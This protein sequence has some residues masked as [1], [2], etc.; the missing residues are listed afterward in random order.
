MKQLTTDVMIK[1]IYKYMKINYITVSISPNV[2]STFDSQW[3]VNLANETVNLLKLKKTVEFSILITSNRK[4]K[5]LNKKYRNIDEPT[6]VLSFYMPQNSN[7]KNVDFITP[8]DSLIHLGEIIISY[9]QTVKQAMEESVNVSMEL[10]VLTVHGILHLLGYDHELPE[11]EKKMREKE[12]EVKAKL[13]R[14]IP[15]LF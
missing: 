12:E 13:M 5:Q 14:F 15:L 8:P 9:E 2:S 6:D 4:I 1:K 3:L 11:E 10:M 7:K